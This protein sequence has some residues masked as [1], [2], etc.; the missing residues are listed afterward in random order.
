MVESIISF[1]APAER[2]SP[3][4]NTY[5]YHIVRIQSSNIEENNFFKSLM[6]L[7]FINF[8]IEDCSHVILAID[9]NVDPYKYY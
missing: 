6:I 5:T 1:H 4:S 7:K 9:W 3:R 2:S 8:R